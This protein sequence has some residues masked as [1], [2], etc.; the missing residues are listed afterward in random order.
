MRLAVL[1]LF[2]A[3]CSP[4]LTPTE[5]RD[6]TGHAVTLQHCQDVARDTA[7]DAGG[8]AGLVAYDDCKKDAGIQ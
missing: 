4:A 7:K 1:F 2:A 6:L 3:A 5:Q 8:D